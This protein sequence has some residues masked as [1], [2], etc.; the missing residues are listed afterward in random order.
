M[1]FYG[2]GSYGYSYPASF[3]SSCS[4]SIEVF[5]CDCQHSGGSSRKSVRERKLSNKQNT[6]LTLL[7]VPTIWLRVAGERW[8]VHYAC[9]RVIGGGAES[10]PGS[11]PGLRGTSAIC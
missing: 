10:S 3:R 11:V 9:W 8:F 7:I 6:F 2:Y 4:S 1:L 5:N